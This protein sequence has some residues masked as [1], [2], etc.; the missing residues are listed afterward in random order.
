MDCH[1]SLIQI[2]LGLILTPATD[3]ENKTD[4]VYVTQHWNMFT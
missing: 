1:T 2:I 3:I 4:N